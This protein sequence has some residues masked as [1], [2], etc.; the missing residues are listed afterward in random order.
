MIFTEDSMRLRKYFS[1]STSDSINNEVNK[2]F[3]FLKKIPLNEITFLSIDD[4][5]ESP[6]SIDSPFISNEIKQE[7]LQLTMKKTVKISVNSIH[8][9][10]HIYSKG[11]P[12]NQFIHHLL[13]CLQL[14]TNITNTEN[15]K[16]T[17]NYYLTD[18][19][20][21]SSFTIGKNEVNSGSCSYSPTEATIHIW[22]K[23]EI[24]KLT[25]HELIHALGFDYRD[26]PEITEYYN[27][28]YNLESSEIRSYEAY[29]EIWASL[30]NCYLLS[31]NVTKNK[32]HIFFQNMVQLEQTFSEF[33]SQKIFYLTQKKQDINKNTSVLA[34]YII[35]NE[36][37]QDLSRFLSFCRRKN[38]G[39]IKITQNEPFIS[40]L[41]KRKKVTKHN[42]RF[43][44]LKNPYIRNTLRMSL[45]ELHLF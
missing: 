25:L 38:Q 17:L 16:I 27:T 28:K 41:M 26:P 22:R 8:V 32:Q 31:Q 42:K 34:Y 4:T 3:R 12:L 15:R 33:Q 10:I 30:F 13:T 29:T 21:T 14:M 19:K 18:Q 44:R 43:N 5:E 2:L 40:F 9:T 35:K 7:F 37:Y 11:E 39:Y 1:R 23:E 20:K 45:N 36:L 6:N 24:L